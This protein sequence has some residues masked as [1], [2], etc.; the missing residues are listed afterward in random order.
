MRF[1]SPGALLVL[2]LVPLILWMLRRRKTEGSIN[3]SSVSGL[4]NAADVRFAGFPVGSVV[5]IRLSP[6][7]D[8]TI[9]VR[10]EVDS[11][12][13]VRT[14]SIA[15]VESQDIN[16]LFDEENRNR[17]DQILANIG[18]ASE[19][20]STVL[21]DFSNVTREVSTFATE[22]DR[23]NTTLE[24]LSDETGGRAFFVE[25]IA[26]GRVI[27]LASEPMFGIYHI[28][29]APGELRSEVLAFIKWL[30]SKAEV[31]TNAV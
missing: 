7:R 29:I 22:I 19:S 31:V 12:T 20:F 11:E 5:D 1:E 8:G 2:V 23:F 15:T 14:D 6:E 16:D 17:V 3:F 25:D 26:A 27:E 28:E 30:R 13:P 10:L 18:D 24:K 21:E 4:S 9:R